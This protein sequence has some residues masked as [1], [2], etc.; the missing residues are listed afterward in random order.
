M[1]DFQDLIHQAQLAMNS[2]KATEGETRT[3]HLRDAISLLN[4]AIEFEED[5]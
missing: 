2:A 1:E 5:Q 4:R 3:E